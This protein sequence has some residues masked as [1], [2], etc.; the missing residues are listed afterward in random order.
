MRIRACFAVVIALLTLALCANPAP[1]QQTQ[2]QAYAMQKYNEYLF[3]HEQTWR[4]QSQGLPHDQQR[5]YE[6]AAWNAY[7]QAQHLANQEANQLWINH[8]VA[9]I[10][11]AIGNWTTTIQTLYNRRDV[12]AYATDPTY[13]YGFDIWVQN[14]TRYGNDVLRQLWNYRQQLVGN[15]APPAPPRFDPRWTTSVGGPGPASQSY[16][17]SSGHGPLQ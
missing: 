4:A 7:T 16:D 8:Y 9:Q 15:P 1:A 10:D 13:R 17:R 6:Q 12:N 3:A 5:A 11:T 2:L 14:W